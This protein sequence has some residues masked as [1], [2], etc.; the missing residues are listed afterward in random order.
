MDLTVDASVAAKWFFDEPLKEETDF[1]LER[2][3]PFYEPDLLVYEFA[4]I[5]RKYTRHQKITATEGIEAFERFH[6]FSIHFIPVK[7]LYIPAYRIANDLD[8]HIYDS[9]IWLSQ[10]HLG[11]S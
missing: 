7:D 5:V 9:F 2:F 8:H 1:L 10:S 3:S 11:V 4:S 6:S